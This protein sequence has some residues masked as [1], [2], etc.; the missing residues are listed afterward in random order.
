MAFSIRLILTVTSQGKTLDDTAKIADVLYDEI[1]INEEK[2]T[3]T[4]LL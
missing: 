1:K 2:N 4:T 3:N